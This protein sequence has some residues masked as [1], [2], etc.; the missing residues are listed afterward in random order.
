[1]TDAEFAIWVLFMLSFV[2]LPIKPFFRYLFEIFTGNGQRD[3]SPC[4]EEE[5]DGERHYSQLYR[6]SD[7]KYNE[8]V[9]LSNNAKS[10]N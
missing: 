2:V 3:T 7:K 6:P 8:I 5:G 9:K 1:M 10:I 4:V